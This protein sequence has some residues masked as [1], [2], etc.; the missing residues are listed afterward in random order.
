MV[1]I[2][3][4]F[5]GILQRDGYALA[6]NGASPRAKPTKQNPDASGNDEERPEPSHDIAG[7]VSGGSQQEQETQDD[8]Q[9]TPEELTPTHSAL[10]PIRANG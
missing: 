7:Q 1:E 8:K 10:H 3:T 6:R 4:G 2:K 9:E 5:G